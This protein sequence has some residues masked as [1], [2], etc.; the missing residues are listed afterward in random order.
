MLSRA[1]FAIGLKLLIIYEV[2]MSYIQV[3][4]DDIYDKIIGIYKDFSATSPT[5]NYCDC[6]GTPITPPSG[7]Q[8]R[9]PI[10]KNMKTCTI[11]PSGAPVFG[12]NNRGD[13]LTLDG[14]AG[15]VMV[16]VPAVY[17]DRWFDGDFEFFVPSRAPVV[18]P[19]GRSLTLHPAFYQRGGWPRSRL[20][21]S[22]YYA[23]LAVSSMGT[24][25]ALSASG[26]QPWTGQEMV[27]LGFTGGVRLPV[28]GEVVTGATSLV[29]GTVVDVK[30]SSGAWDG[31][32]VGTLYLKLV[33]E[34][35]TFNTGSAAFTVGQVVTGASSGATGI[36]VS[37]TVSSGSFVGGDAAGTL[38]VRSGNGLNFTNA[39]NLTDPLGGAAK[40]TAT[41]L[42]DVKA[43]FTSGGNLQISG[44]T[45]AV[46]SDTGSILALTCQNLED[47]ANKWLLAAG[48]DKRFGVINP[49][50]NDLLTMLAY[51]DLGTC[52]IQALTSVGAGVTSKPYMRRFGG[53]NNGADS[54]DSNVDTNG[55]G[56]GTGTAGQTPSMWRGLQD[57]LGGNVAGFVVGIQANQNG[58]WDIINPNGQHVMASPL[59]AGTY[60]S[61]IGPCLMSDGYWGRQMKEAVAKWLLLPEDVT[62]TS[63]QK[64]CDYSYYPRQLASVLRV[65]GGWNVGAHAGVAYRHAGGASSLSSRYFGGRLEFIS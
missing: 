46:A 57:F 14:S 63:G 11:L 64:R 59:A 4:D 33:D 8:S 65:G 48:T 42:G 30:L 45:V 6:D 25:H 1:R 3:A 34:K 28:A 36:I 5:W 54:I 43:A 17:G 37:V 35:L 51:L 31:T 32:G 39:E 61:T 44:S 24:L 18:T 53:S 2:V 56:K 40:A 47:Y 41:S 49:Y 52:N 58:V 23:G 60:V 7:W 62:G 12:T 38:V 13:G 27:A 10:L 21:V 15:Q 50:T 26:K 22:R 20:F 16:Q 55:T 19:A 9:H 29:Q